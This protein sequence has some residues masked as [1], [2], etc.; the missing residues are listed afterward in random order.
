M[1]T[2]EPPQCSI[3]KE[4]NIEQASTRLQ[5]FIPAEHTPT[6]ASFFCMFCF[7]I[8]LIPGFVLFV[9]CFCFVLFLFY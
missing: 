6:I 9:F 7:Y 5:H 8:V 3:I 4:K 1:Q 2:L